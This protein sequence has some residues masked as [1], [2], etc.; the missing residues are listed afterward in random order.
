CVLFAKGIDVEKLR[1]L[2]LK[3]K[4]PS[5]RMFVPIDRQP[6]YSR[7][8]KKSCPVAED[9]YQQGLAL[10]SSAINTDDMTETVIKEIKEVLSEC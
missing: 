5:R 7:L 4:V 10:P 1:C 3:R 9:I 2:L 8:L 6:A